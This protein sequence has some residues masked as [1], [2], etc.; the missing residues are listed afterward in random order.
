MTA[1]KHLH[2]YLKG[3]MS[4]VITYET[5]CFQL[6]GFCDV[7]WGNNREIGKSTPGYLFMMAV[8]PHSFKTALQSVAAQSAM[9]AEL[10]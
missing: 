7:S 5:D 2:R 8:G 3:S 6:I 10:I 1:V 9:E 4:L